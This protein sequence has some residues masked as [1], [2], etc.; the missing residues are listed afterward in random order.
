MRSTA[1][2]L[3]L[4][5]ACGG[6]NAETPSQIEFGGDRPAYLEVPATFDQSVPTPLLVSLHG[7]SANGYTE[8]AYTHLRDLVD[9]RGIL[10]IGPDGT[11]N[12]LGQQFWNATDACCDD[13]N[14]GVDDV[15]YLTG[16]VD[17]ISA[18]WNVA[19]ARVYLFGHSNGGFMSYRLACDRADRFAALVSLA[20]ATWNDPAACAPSQPVSVLQVHGDADSVVL[21]DGGDFATTAYPGA[22]ASVAMWAGYD[23]CSGDLAADGT[24]LDLDRTLTGDDTAVARHGGCPDGVDAE[25]WTIEGG[26]HIP[27]VSDQFPYLVWDW[28]AAHGR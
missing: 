4:L 2:A 10:V 20:G 11:T 6:G 17:D 18:V 23:G 25:L 27:N 21:Y 7:F 24:R 14:T 13:E 1:I 5:A 8:L 12:S 16:L 28:L 22:V 9:A 19:P 15:A 26:S 3:A